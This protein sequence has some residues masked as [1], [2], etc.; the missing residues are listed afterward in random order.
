MR[1]EVIGARQM[2][3]VHTRGYLGLGDVEVAAIVGRRSE[4]ARTVSE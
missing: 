4:R 1:I 3:T 2:G